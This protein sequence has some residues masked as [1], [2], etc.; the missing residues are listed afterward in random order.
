MGPATLCN[1][2]NHSF[3]VRV[4]IRPEYRVSWSS[5]SLRSLISHLYAK[6]EQKKKQIH[7]SRFDVHVQ[8]LDSPHHPKKLAL[9]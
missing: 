8:R 6:V 1:S 5:G 4:E 7:A 9:R 3:K 2:C